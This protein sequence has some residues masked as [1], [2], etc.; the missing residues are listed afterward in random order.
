MPAY[1][2]AYMHCTCMRCHIMPHPTTIPASP[3]QPTM[4]TCSALV[5]SLFPPRFTPP[6]PS[7]PHLRP[8]RE[9]QRRVA[10]W[11]I[12]GGVDRGRHD[13]DRPRHAR[14]LQH[15]AQQTGEAGR[16]ATLQT[17]MHHTVIDKRVV[18]KRSPARPAAA[19]QDCPVL[20]RA[21]VL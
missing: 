12:E 20:Q 14:R 9:W 16:A 10:C 2:Y 15:L 17:R 13:V 1:A 6:P 5:I 7:P 21:A 19:G 11:V 18:F 4:H 8:R 3:S